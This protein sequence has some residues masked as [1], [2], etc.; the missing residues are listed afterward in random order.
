MGAIVLR[1]FV[2]VMEVQLVMFLLTG[3]GLSGA[4]VRCIPSTP[5]N[6]VYVG[7]PLSCQPS[8]AVILQ[9]FCKRFG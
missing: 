2:F 9:A 7:F 1:S 3:L 5:K 8:V 6:T 4:P